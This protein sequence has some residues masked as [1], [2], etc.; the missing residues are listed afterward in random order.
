[1]LQ[2]LIEI[3]VITLNIVQP[4]QGSIA[5]AFKNISLAPI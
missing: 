3:I 1:M 5:N 4:S 2:I